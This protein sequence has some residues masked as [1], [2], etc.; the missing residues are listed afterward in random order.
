MKPDDNVD[1]MSQKSI[2]LLCLMLS[3][4]IALGVDL[5]TPSLPA[6]TAYFHVTHYQA[7]LTIILYLAGFGLS[8]P[9]VGVLSDY[10]ERRKCIFITLGVYAASSFFSTVVSTIHWLYFLR[11]INSFCAAA[12]AIVIKSI[13]LDNFSG[14]KLAKANNYF[15]LSWSLAPMVAPVIG[16]YLQHF[17]DWQANFYFMAIYALSGFVFC[18]CF[19][20]KIPEK[21]KDKKKFAFA[22]VTQ[23]WR[24]LLT[25]H[26]FLA[27]IIILS[28]ENVVL[29]L[30]YTAAPFIIQGTLHFNAAQYGNII[31][32]LG[33]SYLVGNL[34]ND[35]L[36]N[37]FSLESI[38]LVGLSVSVC[39]AIALVVMLLLH[40]EAVNIYLITIPFFIIFLCDGLVFSNV[41]TRALT[42]YS[43]CSGI[44]GGLLAGLFNVLAAVVVGVCAHGLDLHHLLTLN[45]TYL[46]VLSFSF[47]VF[48]ISHH[49][50]R[51]K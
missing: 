25:D 15:T 36:L 41:T 50:K 5:Y 8:Q 51:V 6:I 11:A 27:A 9:L 28:I 31:L 10:I 3:P 26:I 13:I 30:Y 4:L 1:R 46:V 24:V 40:H 22:Y 14:K 23:K 17:F 32:F 48:V 20:Q 12:I 29:F 42:A 49:L 38:T 18:Y 2:L 7:K 19:L 34:I 47:I 39:V 16:G 37:F 21:K 43:D 33:A 45:L 44:A 35:R